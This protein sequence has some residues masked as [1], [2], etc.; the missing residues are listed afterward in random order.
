MHPIAC[1]PPPSSTASLR[2]GFAY[3]EAF[4]YGT[5]KR[6][7]LLPDALALLW[8]APA[9]RDELCQLVELLPEHTDRRL[10]PLPWALPVPLRVHG[11]CSRAVIEAAY[12]CAEA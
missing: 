2:E 3:A 1:A 5:G 12:C 11:R 10:H 6:W 8:Q 7:P 9:W 4:G